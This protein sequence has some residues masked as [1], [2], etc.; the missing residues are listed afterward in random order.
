MP[1]DLSTVGYVTQPHTFAYDW[2]VLATYALGI[3]AK[4]DELAYLYENAKDGMKVYP[5]F[6]VVP[7]YGPLMEML[8]KTGTDLAMVVHGGQTIRLHRP[9]PPGGTLSTT[10][11]VTG[12]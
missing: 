6:A 5:T 3:G 1:L 7:A 9:I 8:I 11:K 12:I 10:G 4:R 2:K